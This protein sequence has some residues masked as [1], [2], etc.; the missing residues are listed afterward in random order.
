GELR[1]LR[2]APRAVEDLDRLADLTLAHPGGRL[3][4]KRPHLELGQ[5][6]RRDAGADLV[7][8]V[9]RFR[10]A[11]AFEQRLGPRK[12]RVDA[13]ALVRGDPVREK[14]GIDAEP[15]GQPLDRLAGGTGLAPL[16]LADVLLGEPLARELG[17]G[18]ARR[19]P[20][21]AQPLTQAQACVSR[22]GALIGGGY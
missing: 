2:Q 13:P 1:P 10:V 20:Q 4:G 3:A 17:L 14:T 9:D 6:R 15:R 5:P 8:L 16:D 19:D 7:E 22:T 12:R 18:H 21:L 11:P